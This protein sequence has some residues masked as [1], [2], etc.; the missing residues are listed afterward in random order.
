M[1]IFQREELA[2]EDEDRSDNEDE[3]PVVV[4]LE[5]GDLTAEEA[6]ET[7]KYQSPVEGCLGTYMY[8][9]FVGQ[10][11]TSYVR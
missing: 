3:K 8:C 1:V 5:E 6:Q 10:F 2:Y 11:Y 9:Y 4:V 7:R